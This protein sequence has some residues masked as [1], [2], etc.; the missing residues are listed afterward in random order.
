MLPGQQSVSDEELARQVQAGS[1]SSFEELVLRYEA[2]IYRFVAKSCRNPTDAR[3]VTQEVFVTAYLKLGQ[4]DPARIFATWLFTIARRKCIDRHRSWRPDVGAATEASD[5]N[6]PAV[7]LAQREAE[8]G[9]WQLARESLPELQFQALWL[10]YAEEMSIR[11]IARV[12]RRTET[13]VKVLLFRARMS[14]GRAME[15]SR[16]QSGANTEAE[17]RPRAAL[18]AGGA[19][20]RVPATLAGATP[21]SGI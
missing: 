6:D 9:L 16:A 10:K 20:Q 18:P 4:F 21:G 17:T 15:E 3:E 5:E 2:R 19:T 14:L 8:E 12:V 11:E 1:S 13:H 7:L